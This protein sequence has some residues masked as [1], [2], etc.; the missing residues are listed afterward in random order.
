MKIFFYISNISMQAGAGSGA[1]GS[2]VITV[3]STYTRHN[4]L[5]YFIRPRAPRTGPASILPVSWVWPRQC[6]HQA[7][8]YRNNNP[9]SDARHIKLVINTFHLCVRC[10]QHPPQ[11]SALTTKCH[12]GRLKTYHFIFWAANF[13]RSPPTRP[14]VDSRTINVL[15]E[16][17]QCPETALLGLCLTRW[18]DCLS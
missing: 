14:L 1:E 5:S 3:L 16:F 18:V 6:R 8:F 7:T 13:G 11:P 10:Q 17:S 2:A 15:G 4:R 12:T 9:E